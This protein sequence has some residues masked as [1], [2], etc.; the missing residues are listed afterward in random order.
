MLVNDCMTRH[1]VMV[2]PTM[3]A[4]EAEHLMHENH[5]RH[6]PV[7]GDGKRLLGL[8]DHTSFALDPGTLGSLDMWEI[9]RYLSRMSVSDVMQPADGVV[10]IGPDRTVERAARVMIER[11][12]ACLPVVD[13]GGVVVGI[14]SEVDLLH[15]FQLMLGLPFEGV[16]VTIRMPDRPG[17]FAKLSAV[18]GAQGWGVMG[19]GTF[20]SPRREAY[21]DAVVKIHNVSSADARQ[22]LS[23]I[24]DQ[25]IVD[26]RDVV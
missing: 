20:P 17:E 2:P 11:K 14:L 3:L 8:V 13:E 16:R 10:T 6:L 9:T 24:P 4:A 26:I 12:V 19:I 23:R 1:P 15:A 7:V 25:E 5:I 18:L 22:V 21:Y